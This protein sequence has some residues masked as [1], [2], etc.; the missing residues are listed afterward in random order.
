MYSE[1]EPQT[2]RSSAENSAFQIHCI[3]K[4]ESIVRKK[5]KLWITQSFHLCPVSFLQCF[6]TANNGQNFFFC[7]RVLHYLWNRVYPTR[8]PDY[9]LGGKLQVW[10]YFKLVQRVDGS[11]AIS[12]SLMIQELFIVIRSNIIH[13]WS[14]VQRRELIPADGYSLLHNMSDKLITQ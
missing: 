3:G 7:L 11:K 5:K 10:L 6:V 14:C 2:L 8:S 13:L 1:F 4:L 12:A 9:A